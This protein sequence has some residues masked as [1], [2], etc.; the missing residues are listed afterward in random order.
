MVS[1]R[2]PVSPVLLDNTGRQ[3]TEKGGVS[4]LKF[5]GEGEL[6][7]CSEQ[8]LFRLKLEGLAEFA[9]IPEF[10]ET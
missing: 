1:P 9:A 8:M 10:L 6:F 4:D 7:L 5:G 2:S 3:L